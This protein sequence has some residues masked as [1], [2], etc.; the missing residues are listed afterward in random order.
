MMA[1]S[2]SVHVIDDLTLRYGIS[3]ENQQAVSHPVREL[4]LAAYRYVPVAGLLVD[5]AVP[6]DAA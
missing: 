1:A 2:L 5:A 6:P 3:A 4:G